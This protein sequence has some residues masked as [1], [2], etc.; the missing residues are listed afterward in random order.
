ML[1]ESGDLARA[2]SHYERA[3]QLTPDDPELALQF[4]HFYKLAGRLGEAERAYRRAI[5]LA[6]DWPEPADELGMLYRA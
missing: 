4:G 5:E 1:K 6:P 2:E 3:K